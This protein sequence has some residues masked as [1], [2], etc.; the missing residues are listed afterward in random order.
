MSKKKR[1]KKTNV[2]RKRRKEIYKKRSGEEKRQGYAAGGDGSRVFLKI[3][4]ER[5]PILDIDRT[6]SSF[7]RISAIHPFDQF[8]RSAHCSVRLEPFLFWVLGVVALRP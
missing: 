2:E 1:K 5:E 6:D 7:D 8:L 4:R 3:S